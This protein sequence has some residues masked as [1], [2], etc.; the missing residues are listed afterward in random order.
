MKKIVAFSVILMI[1]ISLFSA[2]F[3]LTKDALVS[4]IMLNNSDIITLQQKAIQSDLDEKKARASRYGTLEA[5]MGYQYM[6]E[7]L[8]GPIITNT[9]TIASQITLPAGVSIG[10]NQFITLYEGMENYQFSSEL[11]YTLPLFTWG[12]IS[13]SIELYSSL[14][15]VYHEQLREKS[16]EIISE[17]SSLISTIYHLN[18]II[19]LLQEERKIADQILVI[20][21]NSFN[22]G[23]STSLSYKES[24][25]QFFELDESIITTIYQKE[26]ALSALK[27]LS[28]MESL[29][30]AILRD[31]ITLEEIA[32]FVSQPTKNFIENALKNDNAIIGALENAESASIAA[33][34][35]AQGSLY[36][37]PDLALHVS[38]G[39]GG[40]RLPFIETDWFG[41]DDY[42]FNVSIGMKSVLFDGKK[43]F[44]EANK[45]LSEMKIQKAK[46]IDTK[47]KISLQIEQYIDEIHSDLRLL[48]LLNQKS[49]IL[50][51]KT[52]L[53]EREIKEGLSDNVKLM[54]HQIALLTERIR[55]EQL[56]LKI[57]IAYI[58]L[59]H[60]ANI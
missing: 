44:T 58:S 57:K 53:I 51:E 18:T 50:E 17:A 38:V 27:M 37:K 2:P 21:H 48:S 23:M 45:A 1:S 7:P 47:R 46:S 6:A 55:V 60:I 34:K 39:Y 9:D 56:I 5:T 54:T 24:E 42:T 14:K 4:A 10:E 19:A 22:A 52:L 16:E 15:N 32:I 3:I 33:Y 11:S 43:A 41:Q 59:R 40:S 36:G 8:I 28:G 35:I 29:D 30:E 49:S 12:K 13:S 26:E 25:L 31:E 20:A